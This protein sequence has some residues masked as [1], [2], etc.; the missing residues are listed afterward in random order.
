MACTYLKSEDGTS[1]GTLKDV[2]S[3]PMYKGMT[4]TIHGKE[5]EFTVV[6][7]NYHHGH[8][9]ENDGLRVILRKK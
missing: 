1:L 5:G 8:D 3:I 4:M 2:I 7:W 6:D 9:D